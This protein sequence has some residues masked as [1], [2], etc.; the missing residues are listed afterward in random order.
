MTLPKTS[1][2]HFR[3]SK[4]LLLG[5]RIL[6]KESGIMWKYSLYTGNWIPST[7]LKKH[8]YCLQLHLPQGNRLYTELRHAAARAFAFSFFRIHTYAVR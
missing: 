1:P 7:A 6:S 2:V 4:M 8:T 5:L 3:F